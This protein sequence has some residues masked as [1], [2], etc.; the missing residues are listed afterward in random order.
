MMGENWVDAL[1]LGRVGESGFVSRCALGYDWVCMYVC[2]YKMLGA[3]ECMHVCVC[4]RE[5]KY[6]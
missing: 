6:R 5:I 1:T 4:V 3:S 2:V